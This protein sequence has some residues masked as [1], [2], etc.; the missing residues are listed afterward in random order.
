MKREARIV[1]SLI[2]SICLLFVTVSNVFAEE[3]EALKGL[4]SV[5]AVFDVR[6]GNPKSAAIHIEL[7]HQTYK[8]LM[9]AN[10]RPKVVVVFIGPS[11]KLISKNREGFTP[12]DQK[13]LDEIANTVSAMS[14]D[15]IV[16][17]ICMVAARIFNVDP[18]LVLPEIK[19]VENGWISTIGYQSQGY[20]LV[21]AY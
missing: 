1:M 5:K 2:I 20:S 11:V 9:A 7:M 8:D 19:K 16:L 6:I 13:L 10:K 14:K 18:A 21:P 3:Y 15:G 12:E 4:K 17:E